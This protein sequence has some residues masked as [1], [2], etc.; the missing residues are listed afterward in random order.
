QLAP[1][2]VARQEPGTEAVCLDR[3]QRRRP[4][5]E[6]AQRG[7]GKG[8][9]E[10]AVHLESRSHVAVERRY[11]D[12]LCHRCQGGHPLQVGRQPRGES[13]RYRP[14]EADPPGGRRHEEVGTLWQEAEPDAESIVVAD[15]GHTASPKVRIVLYRIWIAW[16]IPTP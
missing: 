4:R 11:A 10:L 3:R 9:I 8:A 13:D 14:G 5:A 12:V 2:A 6:K 1:R 7:F 16:G 15:R